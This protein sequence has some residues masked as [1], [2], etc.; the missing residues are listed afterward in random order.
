MGHIQEVAAPCFKH[1]S[2]TYSTMVTCTKLVE[3]ITENE[4]CILNVLPFLRALVLLLD[5]HN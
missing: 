1:F 5:L 2:E 4:Q 3:L